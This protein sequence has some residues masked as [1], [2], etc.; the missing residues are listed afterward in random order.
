MLPIPGLPLFSLSVS[1]GG[2][3]YSRRGRESFFSSTSLRPSAYT[4]HFFDF[5]SSQV[6]K[7]FGEDGIDLWAGITVSPDERWVLIAKRPDPA[8]ELMLVENF[9]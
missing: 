4:I 5:E 9:R 6:M 1:R 2:L 3:Y 8:S 7:L